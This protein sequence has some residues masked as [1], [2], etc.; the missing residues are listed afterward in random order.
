MKYAP[1]I[2]LLMLVFAAPNA[3]ANT[4]YN[5]G[6]IPAAVQVQVADLQKDAELIGMT[7]SRLTEIVDSRLRTFNILAYANTFSKR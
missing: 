7:K 4:S 3:G 6:G 2:T 5:L 1:A